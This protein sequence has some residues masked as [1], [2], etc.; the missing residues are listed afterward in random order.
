MNFPANCFHQGNVGDN[1]KERK[2]W[3]LLFAL[4]D[5]TGLRTGSLVDHTANMS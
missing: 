2:G 4:F 3:R 1:E 5:L